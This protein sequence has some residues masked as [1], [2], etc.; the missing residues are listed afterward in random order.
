M[1]RRRWRQRHRGQRRRLAGEAAVDVVVGPTIVQRPLHCPTLSFA[2]A[3]GAYRDV[4]RNTVEVG[5]L[6]VPTAREEMEVSSRA[7]GV[8]DRHQAQPACS[9][10][11]AFVALSRAG[12]GSSSGQGGGIGGWLATER[13]VRRCDPNAI[14]FVIPPN[15][16]IRKCQ[17]P[18]VWGHAA[19]I[20][21]AVARV[22][23]H[24]AAVDVEVAAVLQRP[25][26]RGPARAFPLAE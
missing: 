16:R 25:L 23:T 11:I 18:L 10:S 8:V 3:E 6:A 1:R 20:A 2:L 9:A 13:V 12:G 22:G 21:Q 24:V 4:V 14:A 26:D 19:R 17:L 7:L 5:I 15:R